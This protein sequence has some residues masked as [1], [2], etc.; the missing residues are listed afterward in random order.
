[1]A[2]TNTNIPRPLEYCTTK[3]HPLAAEGSHRDTL[4][5]RLLCS[6]K[7]LVS[8]N[9]EASDPNCRQLLDPETALAVLKG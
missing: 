8:T 6:N 4:V 9:L 1:M 5:S 3:R 7:Y 2:I